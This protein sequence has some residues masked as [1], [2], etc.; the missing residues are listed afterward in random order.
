MPIPYRMLAATCAVCLSL[1]GCITGGA[2]VA[3]PVANAELSAAEAPTYVDLVDLA[4]AADT[5]AVVTITDQITLEPERAPDLA[6]GMARLYIESAIT[7]LL[8]APRVTGQNLAFLVDVPL[9]ADG[10]PPKLKKRSVLVMGDLS[11]VRPGELQLISSESMFPAGPTIEGRVR[12]IL[13]QLTDAEV[14][15]AITGVRDVISVPGNLAGESE[16]QMFVETATGAPISLSVLRRPGQAATWGISLGE[17]VDASAQVPQPGTLLWYRFACSLP[18]TLP[19]SS[20]LQTDSRS[21][22]Q[23]RADYAFVL[24]QLGPCERRLG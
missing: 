4:L 19:A 14:P 21:R 8:T 3:G 15:P 1:A 13:L 16:T 6:S 5:V 12:E 9:E 10:K 2:G 23:A 20:Y 24:Q 7:S 22:E 18:R 11:A 17:I